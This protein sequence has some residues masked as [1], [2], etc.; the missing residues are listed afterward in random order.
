MT[1]QDDIALKN[2]NIAF[3]QF[4][5]TNLKHHLAKA[6]EFREIYKKSFYKFTA[7]LFADILLLCLLIFAAP[8]IE[9]NT[10]SDTVIVLAILLLS[11]PV[12]LSNFF[13]R[14]QRKY[15][16]EVSLYFAEKLQAFF[17]GFNVNEACLNFHHQELPNIDSPDEKFNLWEL[18][19]GTYKN[20][21]I[22][23]TQQE[24]N[25]SSNG[26]YITLGL[27]KK[28]N[29]PLAMLSK[30]FCWNCSYAKLFMIYGPI[31]LMILI[32]CTNIFKRLV[33]N[34][35]IESASVAVSSL[36]LVFPLIYAIFYTCGKLIKKYQFRKAYI[37]VE[38]ADF[39]KNWNTYCYDKNT[40]KQ[41]LTPQFMNKL[42][43]FQKQ[44]PSTPV[45]AVRSDDTFSISINSGKSFFAPFSIFTPLNSYKNL[46]T[47]A[48]RLY[49]LFDLVDEFS[50]AEK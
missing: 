25:N 43:N 2:F 26:T 8:F 38:N 47:A 6:E 39:V 21:D 20:I 29:I 14:L 41:I 49:L 22:C 1:K 12:I 18:L 4:Y 13:I 48:L 24:I 31:T 3:K 37:N 34:Q 35:P 9:K 42:L 16:K 50:A 5:E 36:L 15:K 40:A 28:I 27:K 33:Y 10:N 46:Y 45:D 17:K 19:I 44:C 32:D 7:V 23:I 11:I 30:K